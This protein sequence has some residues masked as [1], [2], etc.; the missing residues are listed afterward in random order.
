MRLRFGEGERLG[1]AG[2]EA[3]EA[4]ARVHG[5]QMHGLAIEAL[6]GVKLQPLVGAQHIDRTDLGHHIGGD[7]HDDLVEPSLCVHRLRADLAQPAQQQ[8]GAAMSA[9]H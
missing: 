9:T 3:D 7:L 1:A 2:D 6:G 8:A 4:L 5:G